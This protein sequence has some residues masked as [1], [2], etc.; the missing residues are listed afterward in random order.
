MGT[1]VTSFYEGA[2]P[3]ICL[4]VEA[5]TTEQEADSPTPIKEAQKRRRDHSRGGDNWR[6]LHLDHQQLAKI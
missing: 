1:E 4:G 3:S 2:A 6:N 5:A